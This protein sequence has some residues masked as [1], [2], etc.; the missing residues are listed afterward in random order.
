MRPGASTICR[1][2]RAVTLLPEPDS[3]TTHSVRP[4]SSVKDTPSTAFTTPL[5]TGK[6][7]VEVADLEDDRRSV[8][9][10]WSSTASG[11]R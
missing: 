7:V 9:P 6:W 10:R 4:R 5:R 8:R 2:E 3:P 1:I 11:V